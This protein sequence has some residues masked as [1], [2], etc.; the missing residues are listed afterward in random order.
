MNAPSGY[1]FDKVVP[2][3]P[4]RLYE[5]TGTLNGA[6]SAYSW[7]VAINPSK[8]TKF[9][10]RQAAMPN[11]TTTYEVNKGDEWFDTDFSPPKKYTA[12]IDNADTIS[13]AEWKQ[14]WNDD[15]V[16]YEPG[17]LTLPDV[18][19]YSLGATVILSNGR[20]FMLVDE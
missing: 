8:N 10:F 19:G 20:M 17:S 5:T 13:S 3:H 7:S 18:G 11:G 2:T 4:Q 9:I 12:Q 14:M 6:G 15:R 16:I 1:S